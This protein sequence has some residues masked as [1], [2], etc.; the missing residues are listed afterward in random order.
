MTINN[1]KKS[2]NP[3]YLLPNEPSRFEPRHI[4]E[5]LVFANNLNASD[6]TIQTGSPVFA[7]IHGKLYHVCCFFKQFFSIMSAQ[8]YI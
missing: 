7:E 5:L 1:K 4:D 6:V 3:D 8:K 2:V